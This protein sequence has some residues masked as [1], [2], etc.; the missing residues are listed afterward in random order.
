MCIRDSLYLTQVLPIFA[1]ASFITK[2]SAGVAPMTL[3]NQLKSVVLSVVCS[4]LWMP[5]IAHHLERWRREGKT[6]ASALHQRNTKKGY[7]MQEE[8]TLDAT[9]NINAHM[10]RKRGIQ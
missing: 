1:L 4:A 7:L 5:V 10:L 6:R 8:Q 3:V 2:P 9:V